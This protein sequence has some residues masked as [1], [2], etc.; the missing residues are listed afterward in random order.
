MGGK[1]RNRNK[2]RPPVER[3]DR[4]HRRL[5]ER[6][7]ELVACAAEIVEG[8]ELRA[9]WDAVADVLAYLERAGVR[10]EEDEEETVFPRLA[11]VVAL[12]PLLKALRTEHRS[13]R[14]LVNDL[15]KVVGAQKESPAGA[16]LS[17][18]AAKIQASYQ[19][20]VEREDAELLPA[21]T[22]YIDAAGEAEMA[23]EMA[24]RRS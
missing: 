23:A 1:F 9:S 15:A 17:K 18:L 5:E 21:I 2:S 3:L 16:K 13:Q 4:S 6:L 24:E 8:K 14:K 11:G 20:H 7:E 19:A 10:H 22:R 12:R